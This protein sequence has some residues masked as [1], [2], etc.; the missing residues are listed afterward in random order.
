MIISESGRA[1]AAHHSVLIFNILGS[2]RLDQ[3]EIAPDAVMA[4]IK[5][6]PQPIRD[7]YE[8][9]RTHRRTPPGRVL[10]RRADRAR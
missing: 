1:I 4:R 10:P 8:A 9:L 5:A 6:A 7:L 3:F 2:S